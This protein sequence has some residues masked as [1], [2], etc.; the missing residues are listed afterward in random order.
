MSKRLV[1]CKGGRFERKARPSTKLR[2]DG[3]TQRK[4]ENAGVIAVSVKASKALTQRKTNLRNLPCTRCHCEESRRRREDV[5][6]SE[7]IGSFK[8]GKS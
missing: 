6:I 1:F 3:E 2:T 7:N 4:A 8:S 5:A